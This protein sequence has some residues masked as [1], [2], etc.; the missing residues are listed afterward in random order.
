MNRPRSQL[1][2]AAVALL[3]GLLVVVQLRAQTGGSSLEN[4]SAQELTTLVANLNTRNDQLRTEIATLEGE[5]TDLQSASSKGETS[6]GQLRTDLDRIDSWT[7]LAGV[8]GPGV[9][10]T[11]NG[12]IPGSAVEDLINELRN[13]GAEAVAVG[14]VRVVPGIV[15]AGDPGSLSVENAPLDQTFEIDAIGSPEALTGSLTRA[16]GIVAQLQATFQDV[17]VTVTPLDKLQLR[18]TDRPLVPAHGTPRI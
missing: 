14:G 4:L 15:V 16:G 8:S 10:V 9:R 11:V 2:L 17:Q 5:V 1:T 3:L 12:P 13:G 6:M 18:A 7:G